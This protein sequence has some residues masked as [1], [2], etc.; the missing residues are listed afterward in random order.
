MWNGLPDRL[1]VSDEQFFTPKES[2]LRSHRRCELIGM[3][4]DIQRARNVLN[5]VRI[6]EMLRVHAGVVAFAE[7]LFAATFDRIPDKRTLLI[8]TDP[9]ARIIAIHS[10]PEVLHAAAEKGVCLGASVAE[11]SLGTNA[12]SLALY[13]ME[14]VV[15][16]GEQHYC[17]ILHDWYCVAIPL[18][19]MHGTP[20]G[21]LDISMSCQAE[22]GEKLALANFL[23]RELGSFGA[24]NGERMPDPEDAQC[25]Q[26]REDIRLTERQYQ[27]LALFSKGMSYKQIARRLGL[28]SIKTVQEHLD[29]ARAK[30]GA[31]TRRDCIRRAVECGLLKDRFA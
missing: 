24:R 18:A 6:G 12:V 22:L 14:P 31:E 15:L 26:A 10:T 9:H 11:D 3:P 5:P 17:D 4:R 20:I 29:A 2:I 30:L 28:Q 13:E 21:C 25:V 19:D 27:V 16:Y 1:K 23:A 8:L 7:L